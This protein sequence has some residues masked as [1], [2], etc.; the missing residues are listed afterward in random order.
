MSTPLVE[1]FELIAHS[2]ELARRLEAAAKELSKRP[3]LTEEKAWLE[4]ARVRLDRARTKIGDLLDRALRLEELEDMRGDRARVLQGEAVD[5]LERL[6]AGIAFAGSPRSPLIEALFFN[7]KLPNLRRFDRD[8]FERACSDFEKRLGSGYAKRMFADETYSVVVPTLEHVLQ[9]FATWRNAFDATPLEE[10]EARL[11][12]EEL[13]TTAHHIE[14]PSRQGRLLAQAALLSTKDLLDEYGLTPKP[15][16]RGS[17]EADPDTHPLLEHDPPDP[18]DPTPEERAELEEE[19]AA[20]E[21]GAQGERAAAKTE[22]VAE[23]AAESPTRT[24]PKRGGK[25][26]PADD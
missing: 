11:L 25:E 2:H 3:G 17:R 21:T 6:Q 9:A 14:L 1:A 18:A 26:K 24:R 19:R 20:A 7:V 16:R 22:V 4:A 13:V 10:N 5:A 8:E 15:R 23:P 12:S